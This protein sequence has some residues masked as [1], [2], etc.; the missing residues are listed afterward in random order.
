MALS[1]FIESSTL[2]VQKR[3]NRNQRN[4]MK[5]NNTKVFSKSDRRQALLTELIF[6]V[7]IFFLIAM[8]I[9][10]LYRKV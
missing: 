2:Y 4:R 1:R 8:S 10:T 7:K 5:R 9:N 3:Q 6:R